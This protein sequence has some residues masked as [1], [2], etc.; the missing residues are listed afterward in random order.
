MLTVG[1]KAVS[2]WPRLAP[3]HRS[4]LRDHSYI[5]KI[6]RLKNQDPP[7]TPA[8]ETGFFGEMNST[9]YR[10]LYSSSEN[11]LRPDPP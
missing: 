5:V 7:L 2:V 9:S 8:R 6:P 4:S 10:R 1:G 11:V 3:T